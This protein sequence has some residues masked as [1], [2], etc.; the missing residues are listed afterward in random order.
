VFIPSLFP[1]QTKLGESKVELAAL[2]GKGKGER[3]RNKKMI[4]F[5]LLIIF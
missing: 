1:D 2:L 3:E 4:K 5:I